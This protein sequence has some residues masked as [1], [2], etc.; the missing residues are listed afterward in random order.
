[1]SQE[2]VC[3]DHHAGLQVISIYGETDEAQ[4][5]VLGWT[6]HVTD[7]ERR[8]GAASRRI[9]GHDGNNLQFWDG[10]E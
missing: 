5:I 4:G 6:R 2:R 9:V 8:R 7:A 3:Y 10:E 1:M